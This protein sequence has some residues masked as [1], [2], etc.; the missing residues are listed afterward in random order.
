M[1]QPD[2]PTPV[3]FESVAE[4]LMQEGRVEVHRFGTFELVRRK[5]RRARNPRT[6]ARI[7]VP[8][9]TVVRFTPA[10]AL[11]DRAATAAPPTDQPRP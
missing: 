7:D 11:K 6:G 9:R 8:A 2:D 5:P 4:R 3:V 10:R 1:P